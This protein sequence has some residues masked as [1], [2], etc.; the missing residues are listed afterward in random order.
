MMRTQQANGRSD[1]FDELKTCVENLLS[2]LPDPADPGRWKPARH[3]P[4]FLITVN[5][6][7]LRFT[8]RESQFDQFFWEGG[9]C[10]KTHQEA[11]QARNALQEVVAQF[12]KS[13]PLCDQ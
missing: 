9:N 4:Y 10:F 11:E 12:H 3:E 13:M 8:W 7:T 6:H 2:L 5:G 1:G